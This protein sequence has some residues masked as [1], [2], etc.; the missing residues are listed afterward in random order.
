MSSGERPVA[1][2][3]V[4]VFLVTTALA[5]LCM[6]APVRA[7]SDIT[8]RVET[9]FEHETL[10][11]AMAFAPDSRLFFTEKET[12]NVRVLSANWELQVE[13]VIGFHIDNPG[14]RGLL[15]I[16][17]DPHYEENGFIWTQFI[18]PTDEDE[19]VVAWER[20]VRFHEENGRGSDPVIM[21]DIPIHNN[22][23]IHYGGNL[24]FAPDES[25]FIAV[26]DHYRAE[27]ATN[28]DVLQG[29]IHRFIVQDD[30]L[31]IPEDNPWPGY[32]A[33]AIGLRNPFD[34]AFDPFGDGIFAVDNG[35]QCDDEINLILPG[36]F[37]GWQSDY[38]TVFPCEDDRPG[39]DEGVTYPLI[40]FTPTVAP[41][42][43][44]VYSGDLIPAY[45]GNIF[46]CAWV[47]GHMRALTLNDARDTVIYSEEIDLRRTACHTDIVTGPDGA[48]YYASMEGIHRLVGVD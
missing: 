35:E 27:N 38:D 8:H 43:I 37:Y 15:G 33:Y 28:L 13:P 12:G 34:F 29:K 26:G 6:A 41:V 2:F 40:H 10:I 18:I 44:E 19:D 25:L 42:G 47:D 24:H 11:T 20:T 17:L 46:F 14:E 5:I 30:A 16:A 31:I 32:S 21:L 23:Y 7:Q 36:A 4:P 1:R 22:D 3:F 39:E 9:V 48:L 45:T